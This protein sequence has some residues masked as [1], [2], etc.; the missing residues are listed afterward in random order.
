[1]KM[2]ASYRCRPFSIDPMKRLQSLRLRAFALLPTL[3]LGPIPVRATLASLRHDYRPLL[4][5]AATYDRNVQQQLQLLAKRTQELQARQILVVPFLLHEEKNARPWNGVL[6]DR[7]MIQLEPIES[8]SAR[9]RFRIGQDDFT[10]ILLGK[11]GGEKL[12]SDAPVTMETLTKLI[13]S[14]PARQKEVRVGHPR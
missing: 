2:A 6:P 1:M 7:D 5:F 10:V 12:R 3:S 11:D 8:V 14:M 4:I 13:D 9:R